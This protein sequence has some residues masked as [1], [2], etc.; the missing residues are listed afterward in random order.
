MSNEAEPDSTEA[1]DLSNIDSNLTSEAK[2]SKFSPEKLK[3]P[4]LFIHPS[5]HSLIKHL[6]FN[7]SFSFTRSGSKTEEQNGENA[8]AINSTNSE[9]S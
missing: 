7:F 6:L 1:L 4:R 2:N 9:I 3:K 5:F 8:N